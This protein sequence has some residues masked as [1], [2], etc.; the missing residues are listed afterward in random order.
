M[1]NVSRLQPLNVAQVSLP[2]Q[3]RIGERWWWWWGGFTCLGQPQLRVQVIE[4]LH[5][6]LEPAGEKLI[7]SLD[8]KEAPLRTNDDAVK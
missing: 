6:E 1:D 7:P 3:R 8:R 5:C 2:W 4:H